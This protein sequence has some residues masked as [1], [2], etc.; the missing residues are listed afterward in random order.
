MN[1]YVIGTANFGR[2]YGLFKK[3]VNKNEVSKILR[4]AK[5]LK[6][7]LVDTANFYG[8]AEKILGKSKYKNFKYITKIKVSKNHIKKPIY[9]K[10]LIL[11]SIKN[12]KIKQIYAVLIHNPFFLKIDRKK[13][14]LKI[15]EELK[16]EGYIKKI[17]ASIYEKNE[18]KFLLKNFKL[19]IVQLPHSIFDR[20]FS[21][22]G[23][24]RKL[25]NKD[26]EVHIRSIFLQGSLLKKNKST[27]FS[28][29]KKLYRTFGEWVIS[30]KISNLQACVK[31]VISQKNIDKIVIGV[32]SAK[33]LSEINK[34]KKTKNLTFP[35]FVPENEKKLINPK[36]WENEK[37]K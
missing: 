7:Q 30:K 13:N 23:I 21:S 16:K 5:K 15:L 25:K 27:S 9:L 33:Q 35:N 14:V 22:S 32:D 34:I 10:K 26:I 28:K 19:D 8:N 11:N 6:I 20:R 18:I 17:G 1:K 36:Y 3:K 12:L 4:L 37:E 29:W 2:N 31:F 24:M